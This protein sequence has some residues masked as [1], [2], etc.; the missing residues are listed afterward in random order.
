MG[1]RRGGKRLI[2]DYRKNKNGII[3]AE[4]DG[5]LSSVVLKEKVF[6]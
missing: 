1:Q 3:R 2:R 5:E 4:I 6:C